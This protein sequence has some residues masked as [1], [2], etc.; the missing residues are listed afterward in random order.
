[1]P[2]VRLRMADSMLDKFLATLSVEV[3][4][5]ALCQVAAAS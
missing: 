3:H 1:M 2:W 4:A 5:F